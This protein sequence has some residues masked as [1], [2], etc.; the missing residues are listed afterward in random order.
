MLSEWGFGLR[1][2]RVKD[3]PSTE[4]LILNQG[5]VGAGAHLIHESVQERT[6][7]T[8]I[9]KE[10]GFHSRTLETSPGANHADASWARRMSR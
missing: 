10:D 5:G 3:Y 2:F 4:G 9:G 8:R 1:L 7:L 6:Q